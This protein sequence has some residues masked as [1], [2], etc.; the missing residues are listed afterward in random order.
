M[1][2]RW[3]RVC[4]KC[5]EEIY[6]T[7][8][9]HR[10]YLDK[11]KVLCKKCCKP[12]RKKGFI[13]SD[14]VKKKISNKLKGKIPKNINLIL[15]RNHHKNITEETKEKMRNSRI[16]YLKRTNTYCYP[17][18]N[19][20]AC[21]YFDYINKKYDWNGIYA[22]NGGEQE[23]GNGKYFLDFYD[24]EKNIVI[25]YDEPHHYLKS[26]NLRNRDIRRMNEIKEY[27][28]CK[29]FRYNTLTNEMKEY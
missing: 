6:H 2:N 20:N 3:K 28:H 5:E 15:Y 8:K 24:K 9:D 12:G 22:T 14:E 7:R 13:T 19:I 25:E 26:G 16:C 27:L 10:N 1:E 29:F 11:K 17:N 23:I 18:Y 21:K 4:P